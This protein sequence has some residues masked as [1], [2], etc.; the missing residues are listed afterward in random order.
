MIVVINPSAQVFQTIVFA[1]NKVKRL[2]FQEINAY[3]DK[4][5]ADCE[6]PRAGRERAGIIP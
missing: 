4:F 1:W 5:F 2:G 6:I 3:Y